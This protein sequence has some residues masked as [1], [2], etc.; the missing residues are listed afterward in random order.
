MAM[1]P[2][3]TELLSPDVTPLESLQ[4]A[5]ES[6]VL[7]ELDRLTLREILDG[8]SRPTF[9]LDLDPD[10]TV[11]RDHAI[12]PVFSNAV[13]KL[14]EQLLDSVTGAT[15][16]K[17]TD[18]GQRTTTYTGFKQWVT[19]TSKFEKSKDIFPLTLHYQGLL[20]TGSTIRQRWR[21]I[22]GNA[23]YQTSD[24]PKGGLQGDPSTHF[25]SHTIELTLPDPI[26]E[27][28]TTVTIQT[29]AVLPAIA[30]QSEVA[31]VSLS[32]NTSKD[33][34]GSGSSV[35]LA[36]PENV[37]PDWTVPAPTGYISEHVKFARK[38]DWANTPLGPMESWSVQFRELVNLLMRNPHPASLF[39]GEDL[40]MLY[41]EAYKNEVA[42][43]KHPERT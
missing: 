14:H 5:D 11:G 38:V 16:D 35:T 28:D 26:Q 34:S 10:H 24:I 9:V 18:E 17:S 20:W 2:S 31:S 12:R 8:D 40:T 19:S 6:G 3:T 42:G 32:K 15:D 36:T 29:N 33:T 7:A 13:L 39:W 25:K 22:S 4:D 23:L 30:V 41:N 37:V 27:L 43:N 21:I 1:A